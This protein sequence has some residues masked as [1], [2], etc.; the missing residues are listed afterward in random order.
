MRFEDAILDRTSGF[1]VDRAIGNTE[2]MGSVMQKKTGILIVAAGVL[3]L[4]ITM[5]PRNIF[6]GINFGFSFDTKE[7][8]EE[9]TFDANDFRH[10]N[11]LTGS[12]DIHF[13]QGNGD[14]IKVSLHGKVSPKLADRVKLKAEPNGDTLKLGV[15]VP[16]GIEVGVRVMDID[17]TV[18]MPE[19][20]WT[21]ADI[22]SSSGDI[23]IAR[24][25]GD[26]LKIKASSGDVDVQQVK[27]GELAVHTGS[28]E[29]NAEEIVAES[30]V[31]ESGSGDIQ[32]ERYEASKL[33]FENGSGKVELKDGVSAMRG[34]TG[35]GNIHLE[36]DGIMHDTELRSGSGR[37]NIDL[38]EEPTSLKVDFE[39][40]SGTWD[41]KWDGMRYEDKEADNRLKG[42]YGSGGVMLK[43]RTGSGNFTLE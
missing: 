37:V 29:I 40:S 23:E 14:H 17:L 42:T 38:I 1:A 7:I 20:N 28:G 15:D 6:S 34:K 22:E 2:G 9:L 39:G 43:V 10:L 8:N 27:G 25:Q 3:L 4:I 33:S 11:L 32:A 31:L 41:M 24:L 18:E 35:S 30:I 21:S 36:V 13:V 16:Q 19:K 12:S 5:N 26:S